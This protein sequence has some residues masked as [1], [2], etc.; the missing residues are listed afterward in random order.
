MIVSSGTVNTNTYDTSK[1][2]VDNDHGSLS[3]QDFLEL[4]ITQM[5]NQDPTEPLDSS[6]MMQQTATFT[7]VETM[8]A[9][10]ESMEE[11]VETMTTSSNSSQ[12]ASASSVIGM[13][14][15][16]EGNDTTLTEDGAAIEFELE[17]IPD[18]CTVVIRDEDGNFVRSFSPD[19][20]S[21][22]KQYIVWDGTD[23][24]GN[25]MEEGSYNF[26]VTAYDANSESITATTYGNGQVTGVTIEDGSI[27]YEVD[28]SFDVAAEDVVSVR[29]ASLL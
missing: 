21:T 3:Q 7:E 24:S 8:T 18:Q 26:S 17:A 6:E 5:Q 16:Y 1:M 25:A 15:E 27:V 4:F 14:M 23:A 29:D 2:E 20:T 12:M 9:M 19:V 13:V 10:S 22:D 11:L 28:G